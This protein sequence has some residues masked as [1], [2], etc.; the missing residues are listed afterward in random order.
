M[1]P[2]AWTWTPLILLDTDQCGVIEI[3]LPIETPVIHV[4]QSERVD[5]A[6]PHYTPTVG[7]ER[8]Y[9]GRDH[10]AE[11]RSETNNSLNRAAK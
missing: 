10:R 9:R 7:V 11:G 8:T 5:G 3:T 2:F 4:P 1:T 6:I